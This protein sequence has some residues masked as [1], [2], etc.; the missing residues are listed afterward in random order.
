MSLLRQV[1]LQRRWAKDGP[2]QVSLRQAVPLRSR[3]TREEREARI[4]A[5]IASLDAEDGD[6]DF[7]P[8]N[9]DEL[10]GD[11]EAEADLEPN[12][13]WP[14]DSGEAAELIAPGLAVDMED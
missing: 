1:S 8:D 10:G 11:E 2:L 12:L 14:E 3:L 4:E 7:E 6:A 9:D 5:L 13:G